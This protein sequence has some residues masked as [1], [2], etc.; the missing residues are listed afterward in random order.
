MLVDLLQ[1]RG[2]DHRAIDARPQIAAAR[3]GTTHPKQAPNP[4]AIA[5]SSA[6]WAGI[7]R[8]AHIA[9]TASSIPAGPH[10]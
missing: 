8:A 1:L 5:A 10:A 9:L 6:S 7:S 2:V 3:L 4:Q